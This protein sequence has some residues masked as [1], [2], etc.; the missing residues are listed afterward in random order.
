MTNN[1]N[2]NPSPRTPF[3]QPFGAGGC[4]GRTLLFLLGMAVISLLMALLLK[5]CDNIRNGHDD[6]FNEKD[7]IANPYKDAPE[8]LRREDPVAGWNDSIP[9]VEELPAPEDNYIPPVDSTDR[10]VNPED[11]TSMIVADQLIVFFNSKELKKDMA[12]F[13]R[14]FKQV[15]P[16][17]S[18]KIAYYNPTIG[19]MLLLVPQDRL[20]QTANELP[21]KIRGI[22]FRVATNEIMEEAAKPSDPGFATPSYD[23]YFRLIQAYDAWGITRGSKD[24]KV[25]II[26][27]YF[28]LTNPEIG[29][30][31]SDRIHIPSKTNMVLPPARMP[32]SIDELS[33]F[34]HGSHVAGLAIG[35]QN[36]ALGCSGIAPECSW[37][38]ISLGDQLSSFNIMEG[39]LYAVYH[40]ADVVNLS[41][42][43]CYP[44]GTE[45]TPIDTQVDVA[46]NADK[47]GEALW[48]YIFKAA[49]DHNCV[50]VTAAGNQTLL[51]GM[52]PKNRSNAIIKVEAVDGKGQMAEFSNFGKVP[53]RQ[54]NYSTVSAPGVGLWSVSPKHCAPFWK[55][56]GVAADPSTGFQEMQGTSMASPVVAG[57]VALLKSKKKDLTTEE[58]I[59]IL[60][61]T[62]KQFD[63]SHPI[64]PTIQLKDAL[65]ATGGE[66]ANFKDIMKDHNKLVGVWKSTHELIIDNNG[67]KVDDMWTYFIFTSPTAGRVEYRTVNLKTVYQAPFTVTWQSDRFVINLTRQA[68][69]EK[70]NSL[71]LDEYVCKADKN[72]LLLAT[73]YKNKVKSYDFQLEKVK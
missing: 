11:T 40:G 59:K 39:I 54:V 42:G 19:S 46:A 5:G 71:M 10:V 12:N 62:A 37:I 49:N 52:D 1:T 57:A 30:R 48:D 13:A 7:S 69:D 14:Q 45:K 47:R 32:R 64:G 73:C 43:R 72:G 53:S 50:I 4:L 28:D 21:Q 8:E 58:V 35:G 31:Y 18:Y 34:S 20:I 3:W 29:Q 36:N 56:C 15:Y 22:D 66:L 6:P 23:E 2:G 27:S 16:D 55:K 17:N 65:N 68:R 9:G 63:K 67:T 60:T 70:G 38:P 51:M 24:V 41:I 33:S 61:M 25:A 26:D 44:K